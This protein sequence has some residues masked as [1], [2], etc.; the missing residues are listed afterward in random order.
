MAYT[1]MGLNGMSAIMAV[2]GG[3]LFVV[4]MV[5]TIFFGQRMGAASD[6]VAQRPAILSRAEPEAHSSH[7][8]IGM[9]GLATPGTF[10][11]AMFLLLI[12]VVYYA[13]NY[14]Y[15]ASLWKIA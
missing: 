3:L 12:F 14:A 5:G 11:L 1:M 6:Y 15:L 9:A 10:V 2:T 7:A 8:G 4:I 13:I